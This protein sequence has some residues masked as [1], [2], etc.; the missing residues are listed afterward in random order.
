MDNTTG[1]GFANGMGTR[2]QKLLQEDIESRSVLMT[3][4]LKPRQSD[5]RGNLGVMWKSMLVPRSACIIFANK[6]SADKALDLS[7]M[8]F[9]SKNLCLDRFH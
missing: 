4:A 2:F 3:N 8:T 9:Y 5:Y 6:E 7:G 1:S